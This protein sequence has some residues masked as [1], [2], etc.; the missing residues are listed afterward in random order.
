MSHIAA[1]LLSSLM[2]DPSFYALII[3]E[4]AVSCPP[5]STCH[6]VVWA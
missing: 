1:E 6:V 4:E 5:T 2:T 3:E